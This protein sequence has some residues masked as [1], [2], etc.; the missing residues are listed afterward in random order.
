MI[1][2]AVLGAQ[3]PSTYSYD[4]RAKGDHDMDGLMG[5]CA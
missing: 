3:S 2:A 4:F 1:S 5:L